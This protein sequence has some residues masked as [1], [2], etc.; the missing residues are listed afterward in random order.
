[1]ISRFYICCFV[2]TLCNNAA[3]VRIARCTGKCRICHAHATDVHATHTHVHMHPHTMLDL[4]IKNGNSLSSTHTPTHMHTLQLPLSTFPSCTFIVSRMK[5]TVWLV[6]NPTQ[7]SY[8]VMCCF[9]PWSSL[10]GASVNRAIVWSALP[11][12]FTPISP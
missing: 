7:S 3:G 10:S 2:F 4:Y 8:T 6:G 5:N 12:S 1:M 11:R 9:A